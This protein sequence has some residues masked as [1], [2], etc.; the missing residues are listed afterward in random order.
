[1]ISQLRQI[2]KI[3]T[4]LANMKTA[5]FNSVLPVT[6]DVLAHKKNNQYT[7]QIGAKEISTRSAMDL[8]VGSK[9]WGVMKE[10]KKLNTVSLSNLLKKPKLIQQ[11][12]QNF[13][14]KFDEVK[15]AELF[16]KENP[17]AELKASLL[18][19]L[20]QATTKNEFMTLTNMIAAINEN[21]FTMVLDQNNENTMFQFKKKT[22]GESASLEDS[23]IEFYAA[24]EHLGPVGG[25]ISIIDGERRVSLEVHYK[26]T[27]DFLQGELENL[28]LDGIVHH[29]DKKVNPLFELPAALLDVMG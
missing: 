16:S 15:L 5:R 19:N 6:I 27:V 22:K 1:M 12:K 18:Q 7:L 8:D 13:L 23:T 3:E 21:V 17:K 25:D 26:N 28:D 24:F 20:T 4:L 10:D 2:A 14:P 11:N 29:R 9:Y